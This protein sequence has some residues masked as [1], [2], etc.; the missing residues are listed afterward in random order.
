[1]L[2]LITVVYWTI[3]LFHITSH[4]VLTSLLNLSMVDSESC[5]SQVGP[6]FFYFKKWVLLSD[7]IHLTSMNHSSFD[8]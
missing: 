1:M 5:Q 3:S 4:F 7:S 2:V 8:A 6:F